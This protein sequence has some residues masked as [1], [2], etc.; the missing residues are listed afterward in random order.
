MLLEVI[1]I[2][3]KDNR[4]I[5]PMETPGFAWRVALSILVIFGMV[6]FLIL[7]LL[8]YAGDFN[9]YQNI[10]MALVS[11]LIG[12]AILGAAWA[13]W[14]IRYGYRHHKDGEKDHS[15]CMKGCESK[16]H[17][18]GCG[19]CGGAAYGLGFVGA[20]VY[21]LT[22]ATTLLG[23]VIGILKAIFWPAFIVYG[24]LK[25]LGM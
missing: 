22:T 18:H 14:G 24:L 6:V 10:A 13:S 5:T 16:G 9:V 17:F 3:K 21:Y 15:Q 19:G 12:I 7:W 4:V 25:L 8:F 20:L 23:V 2:P 11:I 1:L